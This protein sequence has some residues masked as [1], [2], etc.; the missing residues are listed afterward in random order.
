MIVCLHHDDNDHTLTIWFF[1][2]HHEGPKQDN[3]NSF[4]LY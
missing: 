4:L 2:L 3:Q 1:P